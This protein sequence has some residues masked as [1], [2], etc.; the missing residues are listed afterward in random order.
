MALGSRT[1]RHIAVATMMT[2]ASLVAMEPASAAPEPAAAPVVWGQC[3]AADISNVP[4]A[5]Q[6]R[7]SCATYVVAP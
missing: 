7:F 3:A 4:P 2:A 6:S 5:E 1:V